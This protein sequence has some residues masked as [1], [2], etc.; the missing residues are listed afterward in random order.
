M[1]VKELSAHDFDSANRIFHSIFEHKW[2]QDFD[3]AWNTRLVPA[4][5]GAY[6]EDG[7]LLAYAITTEKRNQFGPYWF[8]EFLGVNPE[9]QGS[10]LGS[11]LLQ[12]LLQ[13]NSKIS[14]VPLNN[15]HLIRW[16][17]KHG[18]HIVSRQTD[19]FGDPELFMSTMQS[20]I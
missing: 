16:Y 2:K 19:K 14:L 15:E 5:L 17:K 3:T 7:K 13:K 9:A 10:G 12:T 4:S 1:S 20:C 8:L 6:S 11:L 18:F